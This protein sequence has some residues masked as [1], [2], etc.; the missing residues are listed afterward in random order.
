MSKVLPGPQI[1]PTTILITWMKLIIDAYL[2]TRVSERAWSYISPRAV[3][4]KMEQIC[5]LIERRSI[6]RYVQKARRTS[7]FKE[8][9]TAT[10][11]SKNTLIQSWGSAAT[12]ISTTETNTIGQREQRAD[13]LEAAE[14]RDL[15]WADLADDEWTVNEEAATRATRE[16][17]GAWKSQTWK[18]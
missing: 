8:L 10:R 17:E 3:M 7:R 16:S 15:N 11:N 4:T 2:S 6:E 12:S 5:Q 18:L 14:A 1:L 9:C 13:D